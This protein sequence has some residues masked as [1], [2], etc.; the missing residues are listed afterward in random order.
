[1]PNKA[2]SGLTAYVYTS[3]IDTDKIPIIDITAAT[4]DDISDQDNPP[5]MSQVAWSKA[6]EYD[7]DMALAVHRYPQTNMIEIV[8]RKNRHGHDF[9]FYL[10]WDINRGIVKEIYENPFQKDEPQT[11]KKI[12]SKS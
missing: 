10:D 11:D 7:A 5:M 3:F 8:S 6:I 2:I 4:A 9:N 1:M 12:S